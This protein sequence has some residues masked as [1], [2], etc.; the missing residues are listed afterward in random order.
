MSKRNL[1]IVIILL[2]VLVIGVVIGIVIY[3]NGSE[4]KVKEIPTYT[5]GID[6]LYCNIKDSKKMV[7][8]NIVLETRDEKLKENI[9]NKKF[10]I[11]DL[12]NEIIVSK[13]EEDLLG[14][15]GQAKL[16]K[17]ILKHLIEVFKS[18][19]ITNIYFNDFIIQ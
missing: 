8:I 9:E 10:L 5:V 6:D 13:T 17:E 19:D 1:I 16:K 11:R 4:E 18:E 2:A 15:N 12:T 3:M 14:D 7:K